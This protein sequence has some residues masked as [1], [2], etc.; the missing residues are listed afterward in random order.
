MIHQIYIFTIIVITVIMLIYY[1]AQEADHKKELEKIDKLENH[2]W[3][4]QREL[5][6]IRQQSLPCPRADFKSPRS[7]YIDSGYTCTWNDLAQR[8][9]AR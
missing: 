9:D 2:K 7:C 8:C 4:E 5:E 6:I 3:R 1:Y